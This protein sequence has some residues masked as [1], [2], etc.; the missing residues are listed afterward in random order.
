MYSS[1][2]IWIF[3]LYT[4]PLTTNVVIT[5]VWISPFVGQLTREFPGPMIYV[6]KACRPFGLL[7]P[8]T[9]KQY[10]V[11]QPFDFER[12]WWRL[13]QKHVVRTKFDIYVFI[14]HNS[15][16]IFNFEPKSTCQYHLVHCPFSFGH[17]FSD[18][19]IMIIHF[20]SSNS[21]IK[22]WIS[23]DFQIVEI[24]IQTIPTLLDYL[25]LI[26]YFRYSI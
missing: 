17:C 18:L 10:L 1:S 20:V 12:S 13:F 26:S 15:E 8:K 9:L 3:N 14:K 24:R 5:F 11:F 23:L 25:F 21:S 4:F 2:H 6:C 7:A 19:R 16:T 22:H